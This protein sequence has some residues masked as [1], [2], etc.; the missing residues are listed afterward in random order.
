M[1][2]TSDIQP[3]RLS[4][5]LI[6]INY[7]NRNPAPLLNSRARARPI[8]MND[9]HDSYSSIYTRYSYCM[10][11]S[12]PRRLD[13]SSTQTTSKKAYHKWQYDE[14]VVLT[15]QGRSQSNGITKAPIQAPKQVH[16]SF[17]PTQSSPLYRIRW[18]LCENWSVSAGNWY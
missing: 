1:A 2:N 10:W 14:C 7:S 16:N 5:W 15:C 11:I 9:S 12:Q 6:S 13:K 17:T 3:H 4:F 8:K 18:K